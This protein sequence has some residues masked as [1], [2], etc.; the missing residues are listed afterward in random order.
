[1]RLV[2]KSEPQRSFIAASWIDVHDSS[3]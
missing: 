3:E 1:M 2:K